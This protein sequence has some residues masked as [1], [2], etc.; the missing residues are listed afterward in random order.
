VTPILGIWASQNYPRS[1]NSYESIQTVNVTSNTATISFTSIPSTFKHLQIR[2]IARD[3]RTTTGFD[4][5]MMK[6]NSGASAT[7]SWHRLVGS[8]TAASAAASPSSGDIALSEA[9]ISRGNNASGIFAP[10]IIDILDYTD[11]NKYKTVRALHGGD[12]NGGG[13]IV[14]TSGLWYGSTN[15]I[16]GI[17]FTAENANLFVSGTQLALYGIK[18]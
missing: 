7:Y 16:T 5:M 18:G 9:A 3:N 4:N 11:T 14:F 6:F 10:G 17:D 12:S 8:G 13:S 15:A 1:T 2:Y